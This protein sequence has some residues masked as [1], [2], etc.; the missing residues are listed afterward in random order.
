M[1]TEQNRFFSLESLAVSVSA[2]KLEAPL[3]CLYLYG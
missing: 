2:V 3:T 1:I